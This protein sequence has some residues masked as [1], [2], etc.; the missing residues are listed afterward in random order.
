MASSSRLEPGEKGKISVSVNVAGR[1]GPMSKTVQVSSND[2]K[3]PL[4]IL[5]VRMNVKGPPQK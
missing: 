5:T 1:I 2:P 3:K 4:A